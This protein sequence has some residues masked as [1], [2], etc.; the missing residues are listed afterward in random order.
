MRG[1]R[2][3]THKQVSNHKIRKKNQQFYS[4]NTISQPFPMQLELA[5]GNV[6]LSEKERLPHHFHGSGCMTRSNLSCL[7]IFCITSSHRAPAERKSF[8]KMVG[9][10]TLLHNKAVTSQNNS[11]V[12]NPFQPQSKKHWNIW[13]LSVMG[14]CDLKGEVICI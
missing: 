8:M 6:F 1:A 7:N 12:Q 5:V 3:H 14:R 10:S 13:I 11:M 9:H 2:T 4:E